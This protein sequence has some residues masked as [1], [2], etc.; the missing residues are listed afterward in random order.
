MCKQCACHNFRVAQLPIV[1]ECVWEKCKASRIEQAHE[2]CGQISGQVSVCLRNGR[3]T[4]GRE[5]SWRTPLLH[6]AQQVLEIWD[7]CQ[8]AGRCKGLLFETN[9]KWVHAGR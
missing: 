8:R 9:C 3:G 4:G 6:K 2:N 5:F 1:S 7:T